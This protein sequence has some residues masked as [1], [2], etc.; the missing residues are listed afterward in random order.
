M[1]SSTDNEHYTP[2]DLLFKVVEFYRGMIDLD[3]C[4]NSKSE[5]NTPS[6]LQYTIEDDGLVQPWF[7]NVFVNPPYGGDLKHWSVKAKNE[8][9]SGNCTQILFLAPS[10]TETGWYRELI[11]FDRLNFARRLKFQNPKNEG[12]SAPFPSVMFYLG[13]KHQAFEDCFSM[14]GEV[15]PP[16]PKSRKEYMRE[17]YQKRKQQELDQT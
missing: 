15:I 11:Q 7:G 14:S 2:I 17:Y 3:P 9:L 1:F 16:K 6:R 5:P 8:Y 13:K 10:R 12:N 4:S